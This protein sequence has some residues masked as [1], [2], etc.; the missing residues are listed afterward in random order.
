MLQDSSPF[1]SAVATHLSKLGLLGLKV[2]MSICQYAR[3]RL[4]IIL[5]SG[6]TPPEASCGLALRCCQGRPTVFRP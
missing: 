6:L 1:L 2:G 5:A 3:V 4:Q